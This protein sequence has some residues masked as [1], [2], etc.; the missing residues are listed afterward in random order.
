VETEATT[1]KTETR[2]WGRSALLLVLAL[3]A[4]LAALVAAAAGTAREAEATFPGTNARIVF[5]STR[6][7]G[8]GVDNPTGDNEIFT[9]RP[10]GTGLKQITHNTIAD[11]APVFSPDGTK[12]AYY[13]LGI[14]NSN[15]E[16]DWEV[17]LMN[18]LDGS[19]NTNLTNNDVGVD[20]RYPVFSPDGQQ[21]AY[22]SYGTQDSNPEGDREIYRMSAEGSGHTNLTNNGADVDDR[23]PSYSPGGTKIVYDSEGK[24]TSNSQG[25]YE[26]YS[27]NST[28]GLGK[29][30]LSNNG[31]GVDDYSAVFSP[32]GKKIAYTSYGKQTS[33]SQ[34][35]DEIY[36]MNALD[37]S[38]KR[39]LSNN[40][41]GVHDSDPV[42]SP[43]GTKIAYESFGKQTSNSQGDDEIYRMN[44]LDGSGKKNLSN[45][46][47]D[48]EDEFPDWGRRAT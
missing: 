31:A 39:N 11:V 33:N 35:D 32:G 37:G 19:G 26:V 4:I 17:Y 36:R 28:D 44:T 29:R 41:A 25:D 2:S 8:T 20:D 30:N 5:D 1:Q 42:F 34:G 21:I 14:Q 3:G 15:P 43:D 23:Y 48:A 45:N 6:T 46:G 18:A 40:G 12:I 22:R 27:M 9:I 24:Q 47:L 38:G 7:T 10:D 13:S 16:G